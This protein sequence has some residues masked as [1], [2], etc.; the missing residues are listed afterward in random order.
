MTTN[1][2]I[3]AI[4]LAITPK[5]ILATNFVIPVTILLDLT[6]GTTLA[7]IPAN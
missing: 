6:F 1:R 3:F 7:T 5:T 4:A 2:D